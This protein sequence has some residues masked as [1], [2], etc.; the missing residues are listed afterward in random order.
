MNDPFAVLGV[1]SSATEDEIKSAYRK[2]AKKY[3]PDLNPGDKAAE[4]K[5]REVNE[6]YT[7][8]L[9]IKK[10]GG[11][12][13]FGS[14]YG[15]GSYGSSGNSYGSSYGNPYGNPFGSSRNQS[16]GSNYQY[17]YR[18]D[19]QQQQS[20]N[21]FGAYGFDPFSAFFGGASQSQESGFRARNYG[22]PDL[23]SAA[24]LIRAG[25]Y[26]EAMQLL[27]RVPQHNA[28]WHALY[29]RAD[30]GLGNRISALDHARSA[31]SMAPND[32]EYRQ[33]LSTV[34][35]GRQVYHQN[36]SQGG[37]DFRSMLCGNPCL[38]CFA[39]NILLNCCC[40]RA[41]WC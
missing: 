40:G 20:G 21:P 22:N 13:P 10:G 37:Y 1:S 29:A 32:A 31:V 35:S 38:T 6:A 11:S 27:N 26:T 23:R 2:L 28:D 7:Q 19:N 34:E 30:L 41:F 16:S 4:Q 24:D 5:M 8:A 9:Q 12:S 18:Y 25:K 33:L 3:H 15:S 14:S 39:A 36:R 17:E